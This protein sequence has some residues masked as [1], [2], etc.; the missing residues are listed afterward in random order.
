M[1]SRST[2]DLR[3]LQPLRKTTWTKITGG[4]TETETIKEKT[5]TTD[6]ELTQKITGPP[7]LPILNAPVAQ[8]PSQPPSSPTESVSLSSVS[9]DAPETPPSSPSSTSHS[10]DDLWAQ[11]EDLSGLVDGIDL[12]T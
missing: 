2:Q 9:Q 1:S 12:G 8:H 11:V 7:D 5:R 4:A 6:R 10:S 3:H